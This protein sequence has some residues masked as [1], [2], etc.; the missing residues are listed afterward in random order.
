MERPRRSQVRAMRAALAET[1]PISTISATT[2]RPASRAS[3]GLRHASTGFIAAETHDRL[4]RDLARFG[5][6]PY[7]APSSGLVVISDIVSSFAA[8]GDDVVLAGFGHIGC[9]GTRLPPSAAMSMR[10][11]DKGGFAASSIVFFRFAPGSLN[12][13]LQN[14]A[15]GPMPTC[16]GPTVGDKVR[17]ADTELFIEVEKDFTTHGEEVKFGGARSSANAWAQSR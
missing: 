14:V 2:I 13:V 3:R 4:E 9:S 11:Q 5:P 12:H 16:S 1:H 6:S 10:S 17:L 15:R 7:V 8:A